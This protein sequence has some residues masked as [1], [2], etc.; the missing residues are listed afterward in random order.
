L[1]VWF[2]GCFLVNGRQDSISGS[3]TFELITGHWLFRPEGGDGWRREDDHLARMTEVTGETF[4]AKL[5]GRSR[6]RNDYFDE[7]GEHV[8]HI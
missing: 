2:V 1:V 3:Q 7:A 5:L 8:L 4:G 6:H